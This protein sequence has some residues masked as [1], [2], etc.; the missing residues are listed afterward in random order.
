MQ[1]VCEGNPVLRKKARDVGK[2]TKETIKLLD[3]MLETMHAAQGVGLAAPQVGIDR[4][5]IVIDI[6]EGKCEFINPYILAS[7][8][9]LVDVEG[10][11]SVPG[12]NGEVERHAWIELEALNR[13]GQKISVKADGLFARVIQHEIDHLEGILFIDRARNI[14]YNE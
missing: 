4:R 8:G 11:L 6:G 14:E 9:S 5:I 3:Q 7:G 1:I 13:F 2:V 12:V 10:C